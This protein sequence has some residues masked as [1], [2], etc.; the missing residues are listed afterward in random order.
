MHRHI[1]I[2]NVTPSVDQGAYPVKRVAGELCDIGAHIYRD[3]DPILQAVVKWRHENEQTFHETPLI[4]IENDEWHG[5]IQ[6]AQSGRYEFKI[7]AWTNEFAT[8][9][10]WLRRKVK[11]EDDVRSDL[12]EGAEIASRLLPGRRALLGTASKEAV[13]ITEMI[14]LMQSPCDD[15]SPALDRALSP[16]A[17]HLFSLIKIPRDVA[18]SAMF[19]ITVE[20]V[21]AKFSAWY[22][23][24]PRS[25]GQ[26]ETQGATFKEAAGRLPD[27]RNMGFDVLYLPP[28][29]PIGTTNRKG[30]NNALVAAPNDPGSPWQVGSGYGGHTAIEPALGTFAEFDH[31]LVMAK[32]VG[33]AVALDFAIQCSPDHPWVKEHPE[34]F[35]HRPDGTIKYA[36]NPPKK[37]QDIYPINFDTTDEVG[38]WDALYEV[39]LFWIGRGI[40]I[41]RVD[42]PH[43]KPSRFWHWLIGKIKQDHPDVIFLAEAFTRPKRMKLLAKVGFS[44][45]YTYFTWRNTKQELIAYLTELTQSGMEE[46]FRPNFFAN[47]PDILPAILQQGGLPAFKMRL[48]LAAT[49]S[50][51]YG[52]YS[53]FELCENEAIPGTEGNVPCEEYLDSEKYRIKIRDWNHQPN[54][55]AFITLVNKARRENPV[56]HT[57]TNLTFLETDNDQILAYMKGKGDACVAPTNIIIVVVNLD[58][59]KAQSGNVRLPYRQVVVH[60]LITNVQYKWSEQNPVYLDPQVAPGHLFMII[61]DGLTYPS[62][63]Q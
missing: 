24:F 11:T 34:W 63:T 42:N 58:P 27:I 25:A 23:M 7:A 16:T 3:G 22:E 54:I 52:I 47:T 46:Y 53:G 15:L 57:L 41:F 29:H 59:H 30:R 4:E 31:F 61:S 33:L 45:S 44:Q 51:A 56:L 55:K 17:T 28:I 39:L 50:P 6:L 60:D 20:P 36:E 12:L 10:E 43:T 8:W 14:A 5:T 19:G 2:E 62:N 26:D 49:L 35:S 13:W 38:L 9:Q 40:L 37:Y 48:L 32:T 21:L 18:T 1:I